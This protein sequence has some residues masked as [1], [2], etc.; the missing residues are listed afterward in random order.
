[1]SAHPSRVIGLFPTPLLHAPGLVPEGTVALLRERFLEA[2]RQANGRSP[3]LS[4]TQILRH[5]DDAVLSALSSLLLPGVSEFGELLFGERLDW[6][7]KEMWGNVLEAGG[8]QALH[9]HANSFVSGVV[10]LTH[11][12]AEASLTF[13][14]GIGQSGFVFSN[15]H[16]GSR[17]GPFN[18][19]KWIMPVVQPGDLVLFPSYLLHEVPPNPGPDR[20]SLAFN[21]IPRRL[22]AW[23][24]QI[25]LAP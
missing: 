18:A 2:A 3:R 19:E 7:I 9:N 23:G 15:A 14:R 25:S 13:A 22:D 20:V 4:H 21:A 16:A 12:H 8:H 17:M 5:G 11:S 10:Y 6:C 1:M 24:Y